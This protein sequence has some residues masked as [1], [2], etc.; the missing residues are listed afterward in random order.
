MTPKS[1]IGQSTETGVDPLKLR[2]FV[3]LS[4][5]ATRT[6]TRKSTLSGAWGDRMEVNFEGADL[7]G[8]DLTRAWS[9]GVTADADTVWPDGFDPE[10]AG[11]IFVQGTP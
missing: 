10:V 4:Q 2:V 1:G 9:E 5:T 6:R 7:T 3:Q 11:V 8:T